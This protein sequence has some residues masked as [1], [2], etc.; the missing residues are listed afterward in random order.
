M[1]RARV[2]PVFPSDR[3]GNLRICLS[4]ST[5]QGRV[6]VEIGKEG[7]R[8]ENGAFTYYGV[9]A[10]TVPS[11]GKL[12]PRPGPGS[13]P[14]LPLAPVPP[15]GRSAPGSAAFSPLCAMQWEGTRA[16]YFQGSSLLLTFISVKPFLRGSV[17][18]NFPKFS[19]SPF[20]GGLVVWSL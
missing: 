13:W 20:P 16:A 17:F 15:V 2:F 1:S 10:L 12:Q 8:F 6:E 5:S 19:H 11:S 3:R 7:L 14:S 18:A 9:S 4:S